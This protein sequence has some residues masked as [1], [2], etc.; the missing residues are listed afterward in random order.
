MQWTFE[1]GDAKVRARLPG[2]SLRHSGE[3]FLGHRDTWQDRA[4][5]VEQRLLSRETTGVTT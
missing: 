5:L 1:D 2:P 4:E 3:G